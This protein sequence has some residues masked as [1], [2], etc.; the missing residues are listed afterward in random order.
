[1]T[2]ESYVIGNLIGWLVPT[3]ILVTILIMILIY[4]LNK[5]EKEVN[6]F[7]KK[8]NDLGIVLVMVAFVVYPICILGTY[9]GYILFVIIDAL[10]LILLA[11]GMDVRSKSV[12]FNGDK[13]VVDQNKAWLLFFDRTYCIFHTIIGIIPG[14]IGYLMFFISAGYEIGQLYAAKTIQFCTKHRDQEE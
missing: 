7:F 6:K 8:Y 14:I 11:A 2:H 9:T 4:H 1:M 12:F 5:Y 13:Y 10:C 3:G